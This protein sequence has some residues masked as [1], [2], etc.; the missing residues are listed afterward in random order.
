M[1]T[2]R[3]E[4]EIK[5]KITNYKS[6]LVRLDELGITLSK[7]SIQHDQVFWPNGAKFED[8]TSGT[9]VLRI[10]DENDQFLFTLKQ[11]SKERELTKIEKE[12]IIDDANSLKEILEIIGFYKVLNINKSRRTAHHNEFTI[13]IDE[14][15]NL[16]HFIEIEQMTSGN[17]DQTVKN[18]LEFLI[19]LG[20]KESDI[21]EKGYDTLLLNK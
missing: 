7:P 17:E 12:T 21:I 4:I 9:P 13:C 16:G 3:K 20:V 1:T 8:L 11:R 6:L 14:V 18:L 19:T 5:A 10:R 15:E 2:T